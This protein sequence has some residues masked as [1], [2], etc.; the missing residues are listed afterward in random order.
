MLCINI[1]KCWQ[2]LLKV[3]KK[4][5]IPR[6][7]LLLQFLKLFYNI[8]FIKSGYPCQLDQ[9]MNQSLLHLSLPSSLSQ[10]VKKALNETWKFHCG[11]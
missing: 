7:R 10:L 1:C 2:S 3:E 8:L 5:L 9:I 6:A 4:P 11:Y